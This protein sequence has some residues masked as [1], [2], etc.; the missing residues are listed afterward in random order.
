MRVRAGAAQPHTC[1][2]ESTKPGTTYKISAETMKC[3]LKSTNVTN[4]TYKTIETTD[5]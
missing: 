2:C 3:L 1:T 4:E 5:A